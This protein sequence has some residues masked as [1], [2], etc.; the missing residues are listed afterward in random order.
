LSHSCP[1]EEW[2][3]H[4]SDNAETVGKPE[5]VGKVTLMK[6]VVLQLGKMLSAGQGL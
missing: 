4:R 5:S 1:N 3:W 6:C 2:K